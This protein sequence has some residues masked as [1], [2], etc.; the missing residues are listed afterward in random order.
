MP[1]FVVHWNDNEPG[2]YPNFFRKKFYFFSNQPFLPAFKES[3][4]VLKRL[5]G[6]PSFL[7]FLFSL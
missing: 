6:V 5:S 2:I 7:R 3:D 1:D 4:L